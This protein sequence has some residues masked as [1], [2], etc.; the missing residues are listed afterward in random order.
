MDVRQVSKDFHD[1]KGRRVRVLR[2]VS[3]HM[4]VAVLH[5]GHLRAMVTATEI[6]AIIAP[7]M[8]ASYTAPDSVDDLVNRNVTRVL[9]LIGVEVPG[10]TQWQGTPASPGRA[11][12]ADGVA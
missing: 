2:N 3:L 5:L 6:G 4:I 1:D 8:P 9:S 7:P 12:T 10:A 11:R